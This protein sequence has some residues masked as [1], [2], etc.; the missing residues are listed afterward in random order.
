[1]L[2]GLGVLGGIAV[3]TI[4]VRAASFALDEQVS[5]PTPLLCTSGSSFVTGMMVGLVM[6]AV[7]VAA[8]K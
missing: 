5:L 2:R 1:M 7:V 3:G 6:G 4:V 8:V